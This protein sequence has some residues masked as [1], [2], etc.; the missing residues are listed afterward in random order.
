MHYF[1]FRGDSVTDVVNVARQLRKIGID[2]TEAKPYPEYATDYWATFF[3]DPDGVR[4]E[5][6]N[7]RQEHRDRHDHWEKR[8]LQSLPLSA[9]GKHER[10][11]KQKV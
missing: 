8:R 2:A 11:R 7:Y 1:C 6:T 5:I 10:S 3:S 4:L 9:A